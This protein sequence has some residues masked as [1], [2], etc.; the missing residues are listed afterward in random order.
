YSLGLC[1]IGLDQWGQ[2]AWFAFTPSEV[3]QK[4]ISTY[5][6][7]VNEYPESSLADDALL[8][9][10][11]YT[12]DAGY[13]EK[14]I[15]EYPQG[16]MVEK[17]QKLQEEVL[18]KRELAKKMGV[19]FYPG[20]TPYSYGQPISYKLLA[21]GNA[22]AASPELQTTEPVPEEVKKW[23]AANSWQPYTG[24]F[25]SGQWRYIFI[26]AG[27]KPTAGYKIEIVNI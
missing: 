24:S 14:I 15:R 8:V 7:F 27:A 6:Q 17:A 13:L 23:A 4:I 26:A 12:G 11:A 3:R 10:G 25:T 19:P 20:S 18:K 2:D 22:G 16:D 9:L 5:R 21:A 1:Y